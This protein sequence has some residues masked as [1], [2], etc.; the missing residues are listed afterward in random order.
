MSWST[1]VGEIYCSHIESPG[2]NVL[3]NSS[4]YFQNERAQRS[5]GTM[6]LRNRVCSTILNIFVDVN[7]EWPGK[8]AKE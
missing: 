6:K 5:P 8:N 7:I 4:R 1:N 2:F 3:M